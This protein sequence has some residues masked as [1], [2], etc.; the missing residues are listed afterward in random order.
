[1]TADFSSWRSVR[2]FTIPVSHVL[3]AGRKDLRTR[4]PPHSGVTTRSEIEMTSSLSSKKLCVDR[5]ISPSETDGKQI[6]APIVPHQPRGD[7]TNL[8]RNISTGSPPLCCYSQPASPQLCSWLIELSSICHVSVSAASK[9]SWLERGIL[10]HFPLD[11]H[12]P[13]RCGT[14]ML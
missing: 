5:T 2:V 6:N 14:N 3:A 7:L 10:G 13:P 1:M 12:S 4:T 8:A 11:L 9:P